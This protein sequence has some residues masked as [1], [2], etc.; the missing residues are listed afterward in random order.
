MSYKICQKKT[1]LLIFLIAVIIC[2]SGC[3]QS[4]SVPKPGYYSG[5]AGLSSLYLTKDGYYHLQIS[6]PGYAGQTGKYTYNPDSDTVSLD[7]GWIFS[8][9]D[10]S[11][12]QAILAIKS[13]IE[14]KGLFFTWWDENQGS[15]GSSWAISMIAD[16]KQ[17]K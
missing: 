10:L 4:Q 13:P 14:Y 1:Y 11:E 3:L 5:N 16:Y 9:S 6:L 12:T 2:F 17:K 7:N 8:F 15:S